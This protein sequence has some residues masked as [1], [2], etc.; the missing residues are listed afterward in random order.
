MIFP[1]AGLHPRVRLWGMLFGIMPEP[2]S[3]ERGAEGF[4]IG[5]D[6]VA[7]KVQ[8]LTGAL[9]RVGMTAAAGIRITTGMI[10]GSAAWRAVG[11]M[12]ISIAMPPE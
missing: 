7:S 12:P 9:R 10:P 6:G 1:K 8:R 2:R 11:S 3:G 4:G 5:H